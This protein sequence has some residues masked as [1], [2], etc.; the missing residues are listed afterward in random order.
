[1]R[2]MISVAAAAGAV[3]GTVAVTGADRASAS[4]TT[5]LRLSGG[6]TLEIPRAWRVYRS[7]DQVHVVT[8]A[9]AKPKGHYFEPR[10]RGFWVMG[11]K[12]LKTGGEGFRRYNPVDGPF[13]PAVD[14]APCPTDPKLGHV[15]GKAIAVGH[16]NIGEGHKA[17]YRVWP[18]RCVTND[19][20]TEKSTFKQREWYLP[21]ERLL[22]VDQ[23]ATP[24]LATVLQNATWKS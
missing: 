4:S 19:D 7:A 11:A 24:G 18:G 6:L 16:R 21:K 10:C 5:S 13:Y 9:C 12:T 3:I 14:V 2:K 17:H 1:M 22:V 8:G 20:A 15:L 23:W